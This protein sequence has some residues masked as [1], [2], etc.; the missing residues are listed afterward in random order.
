[1]RKGIFLLGAA[2]LTGAIPLS[3]QTTETTETTPMPA[4]TKTMWYDSATGARHFKVEQITNDNGVQKKTVQQV[5][6]R[7]KGAGGAASVVVSDSVSMEDVLIEAGGEGKNVVRL[8]RMVP[9]NATATT[10]TTDSTTMIQDVLVNTD[11][12]SHVQFYD[13]QMDAPQILLNSDEG[14]S[15]LSIEQI[16]QMEMPAG[17]EGQ[18]QIMTVDIRGEEDGEDMMVVGDPSQLQFVDIQNVENVR[19]E[20]GSATVEVELEKLMEE[21]KAR[22]GELKEV[23]EQTNPESRKVRKEIR[24]VRRS[25]D[26]AQMLM[27]LAREEMAKLDGSKTVRT[28]RSVAHPTKCDSA[29]MSRIHHVWEVAP[30]NTPSSPAV[31]RFRLRT[32]PPDAPIPPDAPVAPVAPVPPFPPDADILIKAF[33]CPQMTILSGDSVSI[34]EE[35]NGERVVRVF[36]LGNRDTTL[37]INET[38]NDGTHRTITLFNGPLTM[39]NAGSKGLRVIC[40]RGDSMV[41]NVDQKVIVIGPRYA[42]AKQM[43]E[44]MKQNEEKPE[45]VVKSTVVARAAGYRLHDAMPNPANGSVTVNFTLPQAGQATLEL[46]DAN[47]TA[48]KK[49]A[50]GDHTAGDHSVTFDTSD[51]SSGTYFYRLT[52]GNFVQSKALQVVK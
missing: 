35:K 43:L 49:M 37:V 41:A 50:D 23:L 28:I 20:G 27:E 16:E 25:L 30:A 32:V 26:S 17:M 11:D 44:T 21:L 45:A 24:I 34:V 36:E 51:L 48:V 22:D 33:S 42:E 12:G 39:M 1:M 9:P 31:R 3:A 38:G 52:S 8:R 18:P 29:T 4:T 15:E 47:G 2:L 46:Y 6:V 13:I 5:V 40:M 14:D 19:I 10:W 7:S